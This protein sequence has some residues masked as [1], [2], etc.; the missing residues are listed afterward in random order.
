MNL[1]IRF[2]KI[3]KL[4]QSYKI[5]SSINKQDLLAHIKSK[6]DIGQVGFID[7]YFDLYSKSPNILIG[8]ISDNGFA[9][10]ERKRVFTFNFSTALIYCNLVEVDNK[11]CIEY[12]ING[13]DIILVCF[14]IL[15]IILLIPACYFCVV[16]LNFFSIV[17]LFYPLFFITLAYFTMRSN[18]KRMKVALDEL[19]DM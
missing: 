13:L 17:L 19:I 9:I 14:I 6:I 5:H 3:V 2:A 7:F 12:I 15:N 1:M 4:I 10:R 8:T 11:L 16:S 18:I